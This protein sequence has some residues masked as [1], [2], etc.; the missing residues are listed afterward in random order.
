MVSIL[1]IFSMLYLSLAD[2][3]LALTSTK[4]NIIGPG[5][6]QVNSYTG[7]LFHQRT[8]LFI[9]GR[10]LSLEIKFSYNS[11][12][13][14]KDWGYGDGWSF[15]YSMQY[16]FDILDLIIERSDGRKDEF[17]WNGSSYDPPTGVFD[18]LEEYQSGKFRLTTKQGLKYFFDE[19]SHK[20]LTKIEDANGNSI[21]ITY[22]DGNPT[23]I[24]DPSGRNLTLTWT[25]GRLTQITDANASPTRTIS[26]QYNG[27]GNP[28]QVTDPAGNTT[29]YTYGSW[30]NITSITDA[31]S[32]TVN[33]S[34]NANKAI[35]G[36]SVAI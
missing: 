28:V 6:N 17:V 32:N 31:R 18:V 15:T 30:S 3:A 35:S 9:P 27:S 33:I 16:Y 11:G 25:G 14:L 26:Y 1:C 23:T 29:S 22:T 4:P 34:Y 19:S 13:T 10:G 12:R 8:D 7:N 36:I 20:K 2:V 24:T 21:T 5:G